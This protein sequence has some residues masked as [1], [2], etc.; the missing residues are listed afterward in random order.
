MI[1]HLVKSLRELII[2]IISLS[3]VSATTNWGKWVLLALIMFTL[4]I[5]YLKWRFTTYELSDSEFRLH[6]GSLQKTKTVISHSRIQTVDLTQSAIQRL[7]GLATLRIETPSGEDAEVELVGL[8]LEIAEELKRK[9]LDE[10]DLDQSGNLVSIQLSQVVENQSDHDMESAYTEKSNSNFISEKK[11]KKITPSELR[12]LGFTSFHLAFIAVLATLFNNLI[13][14]LDQFHL[15]DQ[16]K[17]IMSGINWTSQTMIILEIGIAILVAWLCS[18]GFTYLKF[19]QFQLIRLPSSLQVERGFFE[20]NRTSIQIKKIQAVRVIETPIRQWFGWVSIAVECTSNDDNKE[21]D[22][23]FPFIRKEYLG[24]FFAEFLPEFQQIADASLKRV[25][26]IPFK[27]M[28]WGEI[29]LS[30]SVAG[31]ICYFWFPNWYWFAALGSILSI[32]FIWYSWIVYRDEGYALIEKTLIHR[33][34][35]INRVTEIMNHKSIQYKKIKQTPFYRKN[36]LAQW[37][38]TL[39]TGHSV[40]ISY[41][42]QEEAEQMMEL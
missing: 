26:P 16:F 33:K 17:Q 29:L 40:E 32:G 5:I 23:L 12:R 14:F 22:V 9:M 30:L 34:R 38:S 35:G 15:K 31:G 2:P 7:L 13:D 25:S 11:V 24:E 37:S 10:K 28:I 42:A 8:E 6:K 1:L 41:I 21:K 3:A 39:L 36:R 20:K 18:V 19:Y 4:V 27:R